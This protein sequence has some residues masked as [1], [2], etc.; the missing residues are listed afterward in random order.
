MDFTFSTDFNRYFHGPGCKWLWH[1][2]QDAILHLLPYLAESSRPY[3]AEVL[4]GTAWLF[5]QKIYA[6]KGSE[7]YASRVGL[8]RLRKFLSRRYFNIRGYPSALTFA[9]AAFSAASS[10]LRWARRLA[11]SDASAEAS[12]PP[13]FKAETRWA[14]RRIFSCNSVILIPPIRH[15]VCAMGI[16]TDMGTTFHGAS[17]PCGHP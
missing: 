15:V 11:S 9:L 1:R 12:F 16:Y 8:P 4:S 14:S 10:S 13:F 2:W 6:G 5:F 7:L 3:A 17:F